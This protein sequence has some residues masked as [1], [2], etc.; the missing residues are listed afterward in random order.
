M[1][2]AGD[3]SYTTNDEE[4]IVIEHAAGIAE[5]IDQANDTEVGVLINDANQKLARVG[6]KIVVDPK[7]DAAAK[8]VADML[9]SG[10]EHRLGLTGDRVETQEAQTDRRQRIARAIALRKS[11]RPLRINRPS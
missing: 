6:L 2:E 8:R 3:F 7:A 4:L 10:V 1:V 11:N 5:T 9:A